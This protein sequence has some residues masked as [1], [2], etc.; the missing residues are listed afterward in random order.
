MRIRQ[1]QRDTEQIEVLQ[2]RAKRMYTQFMDHWRSWRYKNLT[3]LFL[4]VIFALILTKLEPFHI[5]LLNLGSLG[6]LGAFIAGALF[7][8]TFTFAT[9]T[10]I[11]LILAET[12]SPWEIGLIAGLGAVAGDFTIFSFI[13]NNLMEELKLVYYHLKGDKLDQLLHTKY[14]SWS[15]PVIGAII[16]ASPLPDEVGVSLLGISKMK[17]YQFLI[18]SF[19]LNAIGI[20]AVISTSLIIKP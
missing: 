9:G 10:V 19:L 18:I 15:L 7:V 4:S 17:T 11:L 20:F 8:S 12:L 14:F 5:L 13:K 1:A 6:Y 3:M 16:I 2:A